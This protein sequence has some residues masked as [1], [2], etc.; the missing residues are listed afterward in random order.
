MNITAGVLISV[1]DKRSRKKDVVERLGRQALTE[2]AMAK[3][4]RRRV[5]EEERRRK[6][7][8]ELNG[9]KKVDPEEDGQVGERKSKGVGEEVE[10]EGRKSLQL[11]S[12]SGSG[13][14]RTSM[15]LPRKPVGADAASTGRTSKDEESGRAIG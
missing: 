4:E 8:E 6:L 12:V 10:A 1:G 3:V 11:D 9:E 15:N 13:S 14:R 7:E 5:R 2:E